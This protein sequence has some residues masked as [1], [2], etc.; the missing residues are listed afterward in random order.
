MSRGGIGR[1]VGGV[2]LVGKSGVYGVGLVGVG[3][4]GGWGGV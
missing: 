1:G 2:W 4:V 3:L